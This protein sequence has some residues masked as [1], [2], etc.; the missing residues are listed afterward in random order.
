MTADQAA[1]RHEVSHEAARR[2]LEQLVDV[3]VLNRTTAAR[4][5]HVYE[6]IEVF[7]ALEQLEQ[8]AAA[9]TAS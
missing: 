7:D 2:A 6:A 9:L 8:E 5:L 4:N 1:D 3:G